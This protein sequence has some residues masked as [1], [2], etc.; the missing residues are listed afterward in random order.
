MTVDVPVLVVGGGPTGLAATAVLTASGVDCRIVDRSR[1]GENESRAAVIHIRTLELLD[2]LGVAADA[3]AWGT[4]MDE[5]RVYDDG[6]ALGMI[7]LAGGGATGWT[8]FPYALGLHQGKTVR[9][10]ERRLEGSGVRVDWGTTL[11][12]L[13]QHPG[14]VLAQ[15]EHGDGRQETIDCAY[16]IGADGSRSTVRELSGVAFP[17]AAYESP[18]PGS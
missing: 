6:H 12:G 14:G 18:H 1:I 13:R 3:V 9:L 17:G 15:V 11:V 8:P 5:V 10:L 4:A 2:R 16:A 7:S